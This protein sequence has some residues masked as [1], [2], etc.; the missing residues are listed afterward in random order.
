MR[1]SHA[2]SVPLLVGCLATLSAG[3]AT[4]RPGGHAAVEER[5]LAGL[6]HELASGRT[7]SVALVDAYLERIDRV[8][9]KGPALRSVLAV[10]PAARDQARALDEER[11]AGRIRG[12]LHGIP[13]LVKD[14]VETA[15]PLPTTAGS[16]AL[17]A[18]VTGRDAP[19]VARLRDAG[20]IV[21][22][23]TTLSEW[24]NIR[25]MHSTSGW[26]AV[27]G[28][29][30]SP[31]ALDR[32]AC[33][34]STGS[35]VAVAASLA[36]GAVGTETDGSIT[37]PASLNGVVGLKPTVGLVSRTHVVPISHSQD[38]AGPM[39]RTVEDAALLLAAMAGTDPADRATAE[40]DARKRDYVAALDPG[41]LRGRR[42]G[43]MRWRTGDL[44]EVDAL[45]D[46]A[47]GVLRGAGAELV[48]V[49]ESG[50]P[51]ELGALELQILLT[52]LHADLDAYLA[53]TPAAVKTRTLADVIAFNAEHARAEL[54]LFGQ[55]LFEKS[56]AAKGLSD[57]EYVK[58]L[59]R[60]RRM[61]GADGIDRLLRENRVTMLV[62]PST[63]P[64]WMTDLVNGDQT[65]DGS[66]SALPAIAGYPHLSVPM[67]EVK[68]LP[69]GLSFIGPAWSEAE[70][71]GC[72]YAYEQLA[73]ARPIPTYAPTARVEV[74]APQPAR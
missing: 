2:A 63:G 49:A 17:A 4:T 23:K 33:G 22:G 40:A 61:A 7:T 18:N 26:S 31:H 44:P 28:L 10:N 57:P 54:P 72:G 20:A 53:T 50:V 38:T 74:P 14:N 34:S 60:A 51:E 16:L 64:A 6:G 15:D 59:E 65:V 29:T 13:L 35:A 24:A 30:R 52:E 25:S 70:L 73:R 9:R 55:D 21:L 32:N 36:A 1:S 43:V 27:G 45:F 5:S 41:A 62:G 19:L 37:C 48:D 42:I 12:P 58:A 69:V 46:R 68:G 71:L 11:A 47:L 67:G 56:V 3:C 8:D 39:A 66:S